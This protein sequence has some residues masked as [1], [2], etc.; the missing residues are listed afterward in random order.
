MSITHSARSPFKDEM[1]QVLRGSF[2]LLWGQ[3]AWTV[4]CSETHII[5]ALCSASF[6]W[7]S[8]E[9]LHR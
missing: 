5:Q 9:A 1:L 2:P 3:P 6:L 8:G 7:G 4:P